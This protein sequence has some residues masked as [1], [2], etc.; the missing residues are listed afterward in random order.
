MHN[1]LH[2]FPS[3]LYVSGLSASKYKT[4]DDPTLTRNVRPLPA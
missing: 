2:T 4:L 1:K 3:I